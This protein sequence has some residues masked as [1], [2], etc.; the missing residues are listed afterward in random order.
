MI[1]TIHA[2]Q[3]SSLQTR[4][5]IPPIFLWEMQRPWQHVSTLREIR[6]GEKYLLLW[7][8]LTIMPQCLAL[9]RNYIPLSSCLS[10]H[11]YICDWCH[12]KATDNSD[13]NNLKRL[14][15]KKWWNNARTGRRKSAKSGW[16]Q[17]LG[18]S[19]VADYQLSRCNRFSGESTRRSKSNFHKGLGG[20]IS[21]NKDAFEDSEC[22]LF[23]SKILCLW[24]AEEMRIHIPTWIL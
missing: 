10:L 2:M 12:C 19:S 13:G 16:Q 9:I 8:Y 24:L 15:F 1:Q 18:C 21:K 23:K 17:S 22:R 3:R 7:E 14:E 5:T 20:S 6:W 4:S 11:L